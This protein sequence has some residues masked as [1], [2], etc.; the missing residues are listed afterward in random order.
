MHHLT[1]HNELG[2]VLLALANIP[3]LAAYLRSFCKRSEN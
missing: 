3:L 1:C 2:I